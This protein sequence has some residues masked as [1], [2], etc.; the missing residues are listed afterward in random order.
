MT[1]LSEN[2]KTTSAAEL[3]DCRETTVLIP[4]TA[5][6]LVPV[7]IPRTI[8]GAP[9]ADSCG[10]PLVDIAPLG[11]AED[12]I[13]EML[14]IAKNEQS[15]TDAMDWLLTAIQRYQARYPTTRG[16]LTPYLGIVPEVEI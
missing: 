1:E 7:R 2:A 16:R 6:I 10:V 8:P 4:V 9:I 12:L 13:I 5:T 11:D 14:H 3:D 15:V